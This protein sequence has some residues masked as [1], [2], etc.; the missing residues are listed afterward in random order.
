[1]LTASYLDLLP[2][3]I[4]DLYYRYEQS[5]IEDICRRLAKMNFDSAAW[6]VQRLTESG[7][8]YENILKKLA[9]LTGKSEAEL[10]RIFTKA[11]VKAI[12]FDDA[13][14]IKAGLKPVPL[15]MSPAMSRVL[16]VGLRKTMGAM[17]NLTLTTAITS[18]QSFIDA[19]DLAYM[20]VS[21][22]SMSYAQAIEQA[23]VAVADK[24]VQVVSY[25]GR[26]DQLD[27][28]VRRAVI[29]GV[30]QT[31]G[32]LQ[33]TRADEMGSDLVQT[34]AHPGAR[35]THEV[36][37]GKVFSRS[38]RSTKYPDFMTETGYGKVDGL[39]GINCRH[40]FAPFFEGLSVNPYEGQLDQ[41]NEQ[42]VTYQGKEI[43]QYE[44]TQI[45]RGI[46]RKIREWKRRLD[47]LETA[48]LGYSQEAV[49]AL[50]KVNNWQKAMRDFIKETGLNRQSVREQI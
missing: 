33:I 26:K 19:V 44:A 40:S 49:K 22:G 48:G 3:I 34:S 11:G 42:T 38:G 14:Y 35:P 6:Q 45:Q 4:L 25:P 32:E 8:L 23:V 31:A 17:R 18:Q 12:T 36:W 21:T 27:V 29:T 37:Q 28:A 30:N 24:G 43:S 15:N 46:E 20:Q 7:A 41:Y 50:N 10:K 39:C 1:M 2:L 16:A 47:A 9:Q 5:V 13:I